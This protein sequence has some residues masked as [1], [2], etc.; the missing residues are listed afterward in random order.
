MQEKIYMKNKNAKSLKN[1]VLSM[2]HRR[3]IKDD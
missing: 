3:T 2:V 1:L